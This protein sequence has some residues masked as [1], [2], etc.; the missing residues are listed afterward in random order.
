MRPPRR[1]HR[2]LD[3]VAK[4]IDAENDILV[5]ILTSH[6]SRGGVVVK[7]A[8]IEEMLSPWFL[9]HDASLHRRAAPRRDRFGL[10]FGNFPAARR[11]PIRW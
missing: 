10:L 5:L 8:G 4:E 11:C 1:S 3:A 7:A 2:R 6:G 9:A